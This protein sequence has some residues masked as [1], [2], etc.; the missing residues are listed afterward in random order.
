MVAGAFI[1]LCFIWSV[2]QSKNYKNVEKFANILCCGMKK[3]FWIGFKVQIEE[4]SWTLI[5][6]IYVKTYS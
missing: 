3:L 6:N 5:R 4:D 2:Y 1:G